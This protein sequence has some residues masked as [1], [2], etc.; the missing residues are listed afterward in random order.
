MLKQKT[1]HEITVNAKRKA[2]FLPVTDSVINAMQPQKRGFFFPLI[3]CFLSHILLSLN[4]KQTLKTKD[5][6]PTLNIKH[7]NLLKLS[8]L[9]QTCDNAPGQNDTAAQ[10]IIKTFHK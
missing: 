10:C 8:A 2:D 3:E 5:P 9:L 7:S 1:K 6:N 4:L